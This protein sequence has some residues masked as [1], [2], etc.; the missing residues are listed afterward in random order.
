M[1]LTTFSS[2]NV[3]A[4][5]TSFPKL[6]LARGEKSRIVCIEPQPVYEWV[7]K[8]AKPVV[9]SVV[10]KPVMEKRERGDGSTY[11]VYKLDFIRNSVCIG[12]P[13]ILEDRGIDP[14]H[15]PACKLAKNSDM[16]SSPVRRYAIHVLQYATLTG[17]SQIA[18]PFSVATRVWT[19]TEK[20]FAEVVELLNEAG[21]DD[22]RKMDIL[23][24]MEGPEQMQGYKMKLGSK[25]EML[26]SKETLTRAQAT[27]AGSHAPDLGPFCGKKTE[28]R[29]LTTDCE[30]IV[31]AWTRVR[32]AEQ[33]ELP[34]PTT[35]DEG[36][37][38]DASLLDT[39]GSGLTSAP[40]AG[41]LTAQ[42]AT[43]APSGLDE[44]A[45][46]T[47]SNPEPQAADAAP[48]S[49]VQPD[50]QPTPAAQPPLAAGETIDF[51][52]L[53]ESLK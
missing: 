19:L 44:F 50:A 8:L 1:P 9:S 40:A 23:L 3:R 24:E 39:V 16:L 20:R 25:C 51:D 33:G 34:S 26:A 43:P 42:P 6:K 10:G 41:G 46:A 5:D 22:P 35:P 36:G 29:Y 4:S 11:E 14:D 31:A 48:A 21:V 12:D 30:E 47:S 13:D 49:S 28:Q 45:P 2:A 37:S 32:Q 52:Q 15:C 17:S 7:H 38:V 18:E 53:F 27:F